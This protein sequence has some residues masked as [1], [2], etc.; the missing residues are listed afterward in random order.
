[1]SRPEPNE[2]ALD[3]AVER[4]IQKRETDST[5][6]TIR[7]YRNRLKQ[8]LKWCEKHD[9]TTVGDLDS[10]LLDE[11]QLD[12]NSEG[13]APTTI[14]GRLNTVRLFLEYLVVLEMVDESLPESIDIPNLTKQEE[15]SE[16]R[17]EPDHAEQALSYFRDSREHYATPMHTFLEVA[18][19]TG[20]RVAALRGL[21]LPDFHADEQALEFRHRP[22]SDT[23]LKNK[24]E[25]ERWVGLSDEVCAVLRFY[26]ARERYDRHD[27]HGRE[28]L[29]AT[30]QG[31]PSF[32]TLQA[33]SYLATQ[34]CLWMSCPHSKRRET[35][36]W[37]ERSHSSKCPSSRSPHTIR[38]GSITWQLNIGVPI[39]L[40]S[41]RVNAS[42][43]VIKQYYDQASAEEEFEQRRQTTETQLDIQHQ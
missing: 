30:R 35:C 41:E 40:V 28:P 37:T 39:E 33:W 9:V 34:P 19:H 27:E 29:F 18:W 14:K 12:L 26:L 11:Y 20:A 31:R 32:T 7:G 38:T 3:D 5:D 8:W 4:W 13:Y 43:A 15:Q 24:H 36:T 2:W 10:W 16:E 23:P 17:L 21:D 22:A 25:G 6:R 42:I 1:M